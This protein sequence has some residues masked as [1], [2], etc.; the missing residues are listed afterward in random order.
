M[1]CH[2]F[3]IG[4]VLQRAFSF[5]LIW[6]VFLL[7]PTDT[8]TSTWYWTQWKFFSLKKW[9]Q[10]YWLCLLVCW[11]STSLL[12]TEVIFSS[13]MLAAVVLWSFTATDTG[14][15]TPSHHS[16]QTQGMTP[17]PITVYRHRAWHPTPS[18][19][20]DTGHDTPSHYSIQTQG[21]TPHPITV[22]RHRAWRPIPS[23][24]TD[25]GHDTPPHHSIQTQGMTP[26][27]ITVYRHRAWHPKSS[28]YV[29]I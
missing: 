5:K 11:Q 3:A 17:H 29:N 22:Y 12:T 6:R 8:I 28:Q 13:L 18:Q 4:S 14:H 2:H 10:N 26:H 21:M 9:N 19:Y 20:T 1:F 7:F 16:I 15:N 24:Y 27:P 23:Q 25:T